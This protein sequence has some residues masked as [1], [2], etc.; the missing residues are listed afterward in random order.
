MKPGV[1]A[2]TDRGLAPLATDQGRGGTSTSWTCLTADDLD[3]LH[4][5][6]RVEEVQA[7][8]PRRRRLVLGERGEQGRFDVQV[9]HDR[10]DDDRAFGQVGE[11]VGHV[12]PSDG[13]LG[14]GGT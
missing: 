1:E 5:R 7:E 13:G 14:V 6:G 2:Q 4:R 11:V 3:E 10:L 9:L 8:H 12:Q